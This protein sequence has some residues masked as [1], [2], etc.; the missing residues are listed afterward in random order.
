MTPVISSLMVRPI[1][2]PGHNVKPSWPVSFALDKVWQSHYDE[3]IHN[4]CRGAETV[5]VSADTWEITTARGDHV[6]WK[7]TREPDL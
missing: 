1:K 5:L 3:V 7:I 2:D 4:F 6:V